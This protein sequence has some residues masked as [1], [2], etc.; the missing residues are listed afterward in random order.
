MAHQGNLFDDHEDALPKSGGW[1]FVPPDPALIRANVRAL[2][3]QLR[4]AAQMPWSEDELGYH[5]VVMPQTTLWLPD[6]ERAELLHE[7]DAEVARLAP[8]AR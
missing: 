1:K 7:F 2:I 5:K 8:P 3:D 6:E 4:G